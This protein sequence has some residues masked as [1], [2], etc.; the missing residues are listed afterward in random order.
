MQGM[1]RIY[2]KTLFELLEFFPCVAVVGVRQC[3][4]TTLVQQ[5]PAEWQLFDLEKASDFEVISRD[6]DLFLRLHPN[7]VAIDEAQLLP[8]LFAS[9]R[10]AI[11]ADRGR[12]GRF[13]ITG[14]S[15]PELIG[16][17]SESLAGRVAVLEM[18]PLTFGETQQ[19]LI[20]RLAALISER[21]PLEAFQ[22]LAIP[23][24][25]LQV[26][27]DY[28]FRGGYPEPWLRNNPR[29][30][31]LWMQNYIRTYLNRDI[32]QLFPGLNREKFR[33][34]IQMLSNLSGTVINYSNVA[35]T[36]GVSQPTARDYFRIAHNTFIWR[37]IPAYSQN[38]SK[39][40]VKH[41]KGYLRDT[42]LLHFLLHLRSLN[43]LLAHP[44]MG[45][46][47]EAAVTEEILRGLDALGISY[48]YS[49]YRTGAGAEVDLI[50]EGDFG[51]VPIEIKYS[52]KVLLRELRGIRDFIREHNCPYGLVINND[53]R[54]T[55]YDENLLGIP[56]AC[57]VSD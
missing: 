7:W 6:P 36:L 30:T 40:I 44:M 31:T 43:D 14:S 3:G 12:A 46:S 52:Q 49:Y 24:D 32:Q 42:G 13:V 20:P 41:P 2:Q 47:W 25:I 15:S 48:D 21:A 45:H 29:F 38:T 33:L 39:R 56:F 50:L 53:E 55:W 57:C 8:E 26:Q 27:H 5:L 17:I 37:H 10:V 34:F 28:W 11:D 16:S 19:R 23:K 35:R 18:A 51:V 22:E 1:K 4:K 9:L 54:V